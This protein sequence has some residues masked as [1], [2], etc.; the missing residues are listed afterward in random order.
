MILF[1]SNDQQNII[2]VLVKGELPNESVNALKWL[3]GDAG[4]VPEELLQ[5]YFIGPRKEMI[6]PWSTTAVEITQNMNISGIERIEEFFRVSS[7]EAH[8]DKMLQR[9]YNNLD[10]TIFKINREAEPVKLITDISE[11]NVQEGLALNQDEIDY[12]TELS[13]K[14]GRPLT[15]GEVF[16]FSQV[17]SEHCRHKIFNGTFIID[18]EE[19]QST[20]FKLIKKTSLENPNRI[21][22]A[23]KDNC[24]FLEGPHISMFAPRSGD[25]PDLFVLRDEETVISLKAETHNFPTTVEPFNGAATGSGGEI[26]D[27]IAGGKGSFPIAGTAVYMTSYPRFEVEGR[28]WECNEARNWLYQTPEEILIKASNGASD[29]GNK[30]G[31]PLICGSLL[32]FEHGEYNREYGYDKVIMLAGGVGFAKK[33]YSKKE[34][35]E[36]GDK[37]VILGGDNYR[38]GMGGGAVSSVATGEYDNA[39]ELNAIQRSNPEMQKRVYNAIRT[40]AESD[41]N[42]IISVHDHGAGGHLNCLSELV[43]ETGG[44]IDISKLPIGDPTLS[45]KEIIGNESQERMGLVIKDKDVAQLERI[46]SRERAPMYVVGEA[47][48]RKNFTLKNSKNGDTPIDLALEDMFGSA[49]KT[50]MEDVTVPYNWDPLEYDEED[51]EYYLEMVMQLESVA[52]KDWLTNKVD[53]SVTGLIANQQTVGEIQLPLNNLGVAAIGYNNNE[54]VATSIGHA[55]AVALISAEAGSRMAISESL[56]NIV[57]T[58]IKQGIRGVSLSANWMWPCRNTGEDS[59]LYSA[60]KAASDFSIALGINI[61]TGKDSL[62]MTQK[63][64]D[65]SKVLSPGTL[66][67]SAA[68]ESSDVRRVVRPVISN[69]PESNLFLIPFTVLNE[70]SFAL[71]G[72]AL[73]QVTNQLG[74]EVPDVDNPDYFASCFSAVQ[75]MVAKD[76]LLAGHDISAGGLVTTLLEMCYSNTKGGLDINL[77][78]IN[79][80]DPIKLLFAEIAGVVVQSSAVNMEKVE[81]IAASHGISIYNIGTPTEERSVIIKANKLDIS[82]DID[83]YRDLWFKTSYLFDVDQVGEKL[84]FARFSNYKSQPL[85][86]RFPEGFKGKRSS[87]EI[88]DVK[89]TSSRPVAAIIREK[90][91]NGDREMAWALHLAGFSVKDVHM[92]DLIN[93]REDLK[94]VKMVVFVGGFS[95]ADTLGSAKGWAGAF[96]YNE[97]ARKAIDD[98]YKREDTM[99]LG[100]CNGCQLMTELGLITAEGKEG[101]PKMKH[102]DS[103]K[104]ESAFVGVTIE[105]SPSIMLSSLE[106][107]ELGIWVAHGE[108]KF[109]FP[110]KTSKYNIAVRYSYVDYPANPNGSPE[111]V[112]GI[113]SSDGRHLAMMPHPERCIYPQTWAHYTR[114]RIDD[115]VTP[116]LEMFVNARKW[117]SKT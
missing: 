102:N 67:I 117:I 78:S 93:G 2:A 66:I 114:N 50:I 57:W 81:D 113:C 20:L 37:V 23:Y 110:E 53:R 69:I 96:L 28:N 36:T 49:P 82:L 101:A 13:K 44:D 73:A 4:E 104:Y 80:K 18:G 90:G 84:A 62:S 91:S 6:T 71:G 75:E 65:G 60:V 43:E 92:T 15:D 70:N 64:P 19:K 32:T 59:R 9:I 55:P 85:K 41:D 83:Y 54:G 111:G 51:I 95:N 107:S 61:P 34:T 33:S 42:T 106:D 72:S 58:P 79:I 31:Q 52:C 46:A 10:D 77:S 105:K 103:H 56:T 3:F 68:G 112:A 87:Y 98:F 40:L 24:A 12:L 30:F 115:E 76:I 8:H 25:K 99:S 63:Y 88:P 116:W 21:I 22:S 5:G 16:G 17:N 11:Y 47:T 109:Y 27:R 97:K 86:F 39:I 108:G 48:G 100:V 45:A 94:G 14:L 89:D 74:D 35:P 1:F 7:P 26:R 29:F 38:I